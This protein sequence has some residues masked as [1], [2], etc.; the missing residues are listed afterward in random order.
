[1]EQTWVA[2]F[3]LAGY[4]P[5]DTAEGP[6]EQAVAYLADAVD[7]FWDDDAEENAVAAEE[8]W[9][10]CHTVIHQLP[11]DP[12]PFRYTVERGRA[13]WQFWIDPAEPE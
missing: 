4:L 13:T 2:G 6:F 11:S 10:E 1:M 3:N 5:D 8:R 12:K 7:R 9:L